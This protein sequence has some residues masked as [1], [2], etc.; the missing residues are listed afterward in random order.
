LISTR[1]GVNHLLYDEVINLCDHI[2]ESFPDVVTKESIGKTYEGRDILMLKLNATPYFTK[3][4]LASNPDKKAILLT[5][6]H[7]SRELVSV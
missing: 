5:G 1:K 4:G 2:L 3:R 6:A 7:H